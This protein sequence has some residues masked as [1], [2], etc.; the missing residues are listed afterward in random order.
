MSNRDELQQSI[1]D[2]LTQHNSYLQRLSTQSV[3]EILRKFDSLS[4]TALRNLRDALEELSEVELKL[5]AGASYTTPQ[6]AEVRNIMQSWEQSIATELP[7]L[8]G[9]SAVALA[10]YESAYIYRFA[11]KK[12]PAISGTTLF[13]KAKKKPYAG[14]QLLNHIFPS[15][16]EGV[17]QKVERVIRSGIDAGQ[18]N[19]QI[20]QQIK[21]TKRLD[22]ADGLLDKTRNV[23]DA[24]VRTARAHVSSDAYL[25]TWKALGFEY[26]RDVA[27]LD[28]RTTMLC[29]SRDGRVQKLG[30]GY[31]RVPYHHRCRTVQVGCD[32]DGDMVGVRPYVADDRRVK[33]IP[34][35]ERDG[36][37]GQ[38]SANET[39]KQW[40]SRQSDDFQLQWL[41]PSKFKLYK[42]GGYPMEKFIDPLSGQKFTLKQ[43]KALDEKTFKEL[44]L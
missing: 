1:L 41:G 31:Q 39:Y 37:I 29:A 2:A 6:L 13:N 15:I 19:Q 16:A 35:D 38:V 23:I 42:D 9:E 30:D 28:G 43:L 27:T 25:E 33:D 5:L 8:M 14:G 20:I 26:T 22:Y 17:R 12:A 18:T 11:D 7:V 21:G 36:K 32:A 10:A 44:G 3:N 40:F 4:L 34:K 24:E